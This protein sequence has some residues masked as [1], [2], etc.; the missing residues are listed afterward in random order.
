MLSGTFSVGHMTLRAMLF[1]KQKWASQSINEYLHAQSTNCPIWQLHT[2]NSTLQFF[3]H[4]ISI[5]Y[6]NRIAKITSSMIL[7]AT[8]SF[9]LPPGFRNS[10]FPRICNPRE[11]N[12]IHHIQTLLETSKRSNVG[13]STRVPRTLWRRRGC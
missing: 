8:R 1:Q 10:A 12:T 4:Y 13:K 6:L 11:R 2:T 7:T 9:T 5:F 3:P